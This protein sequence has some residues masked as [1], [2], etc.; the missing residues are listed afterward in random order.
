MSVAPDL[1]RAPR[2]RARRTHRGVATSTRRTPG[3]TRRYV[4]TLDLPAVRGEVEQ[5]GDTA[6][7]PHPRTVLQ[8]VGAVDVVAVAEEDVER[9]PVG[10]TE[11]VG[12]RRRRDGVPRQVGPAHPTGVGRQP[13]LRCR[14][15]HGEG[16]VVGV[17]QMQVGHP[18]GP[19]RAPGAPGIGPARDAFFEEEPVQDELVA[20]LEQISQGDLPAGAFEAIVAVDANH[21]HP[22]ARGGELVELLGNGCFLSRQIG[23]RCFPFRGGHDRWFRRSHQSIVGTSRGTVAG[24][25]SAKH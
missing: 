5:A 20:A 21:G 15:G 11:V 1:S 6:D 19:R 7:L 8:V 13:R 24:S 23:D 14:G 25:R 9:E 18:I 4:L 22:L 2:V 3:A 16:D 17:Q 10:R 12:E